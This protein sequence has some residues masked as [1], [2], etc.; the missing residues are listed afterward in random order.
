MHKAAVGLGVRPVTSK[1]VR[2]GMG[3]SSE[4]RRIMACLTAKVRN[5][6]QLNDRT[7]IWKHA[8]S[9]SLEDPDNRPIIVNRLCRKCIRR[10]LCFAVETLQ[11]DYFH[12]HQACRRCRRA[13]MTH[14]SVAEPKWKEELAGS[15]QG[16]LS[17][18]QV[19]KSP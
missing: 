19:V 1:P 7:V 3:S 18:S 12:E 9:S 5:L 4:G 6:E 16:D 11:L 13:V 8:T 10:K 2:H 17:R 15:W 14:Y